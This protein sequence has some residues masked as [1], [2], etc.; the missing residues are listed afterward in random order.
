[1]IK[2]HYNIIEDIKAHYDFFLS[3]RW[4]KEHNIQIIYP[5]PL[6]TF[7]VAFNWWALKSPKINFQCD[8][9]IH[10]YWVSAGNGGCY[11]PPDKIWVCPV[12]NDAIERTIKH[13]ITHI[14]YEEEVQVRKLSHEEKEQYI[15]S[16]EDSW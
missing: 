12:N 10:C 16:K 3:Y 15:I 5:N 8:K 1:M 9:E 4:L 2:Y 14:L 7:K 11:W 6:N 13:E